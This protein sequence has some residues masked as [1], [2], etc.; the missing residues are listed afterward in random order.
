[1][2]PIKIPIDV[3]ANKLIAAPSK[4]RRI[5]PSMGAESNPCTT[6]ISETAQTMS[7]MEAIAQILLA[8][9]SNGVT[10]ITNKCSIVPCSRS[11]SNA[12]PVSTMDNIVTLLINSIKAPNQILVNVGLNRT[13]TARS[14]GGVS[15]ER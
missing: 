1:M 14:T 10:G 7:T 15:T 4:N 5:E 11:R 8:M 9:I 2:V 12:A 6:V 13:R 3:V